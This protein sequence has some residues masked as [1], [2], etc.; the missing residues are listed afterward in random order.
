MG[1][2]PEAA[3][4]AA[5]AAVAAGQAGASPQTRWVQNLR[6]LM[7]LPAEAETSPMRQT[8]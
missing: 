7:A 8:T 1:L 5:Q 3:G 6:R 2:G 4:Q